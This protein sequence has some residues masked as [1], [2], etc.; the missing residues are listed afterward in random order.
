MSSGVMS[1]SS[2]HTGLPTRLALRSHSALTTAEMAMCMM[3]F[4]GPS[5]RS[6]ESCTMR[7]HMVPRSASVESSA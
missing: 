7:F 1:A 6:C 2:F 5:Q 4:S 3:P